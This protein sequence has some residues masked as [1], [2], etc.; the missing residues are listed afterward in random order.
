MEDP[1]LF[2]AWNLSFNCRCGKTFFL[3]WPA[4]VM[5]SSA[6]LTKGTN[7]TTVTWNPVKATDNSGVEPNVSAS[8][9]ENVYYKGKHLVTYIA[10][11]EAGNNKSCTFYV[12]VEGNAIYFSISIVFS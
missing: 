8:G 9:V 10:R 11:D 12:A 1:N 3:V 4:L 6:T 5:I 7:Y 2:P